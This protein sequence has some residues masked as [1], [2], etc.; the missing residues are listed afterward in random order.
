M[1]FSEQ[2]FLVVCSKI[3]HIFSH[4]GSL[5]LFFAIPDLLHHCAIFFFVSK[6]FLSVKLWTPR[7]IKPVCYG[8]VRFQQLSHYICMLSSWKTVPGKW[9]ADVCKVKPP[10]CFVTLHNCSEHPRLE[11]DGCQTHLTLKWDADS[12]ETLPKYLSDKVLASAHPRWVQWTEWGPSLWPLWLWWLVCTS[13][14]P[15]AQFWSCPCSSEG[16]DLTHLPHARRSCH[17][18]AW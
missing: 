4:C 13:S 16:L 5:L 15:A 17:K 3:N 18:H 14:H 6:I 12:V 9:L 8:L 7:G 1:F 2:I 11:L 10:A